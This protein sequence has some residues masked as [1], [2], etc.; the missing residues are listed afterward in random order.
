MLLASMGG[1]VAGARVGEGWMGY[2]I[3]TWSVSGPK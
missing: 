1:P 3:Y 2:T